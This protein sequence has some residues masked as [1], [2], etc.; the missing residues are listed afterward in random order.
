MAVT[1]T[2]LLVPLTANYA[3][4]RL[5]LE[6]PHV[7]V[8]IDRYSGGIRSIRD[9]E[10]SITYQ[11]PGIGF[12]VTTEVGTVLAEKPLAVNPSG[13]ELVLR[14]AGSG[15]G[16]S[17]HYH[18]GPD[19]R[20][21]EKWLVIKSDD[22][23]PF[24][25]KEVVL[26]DVT[27][28]T[29]VSKIH[30]HDDQT[31]WHCPINI[32]LRSEKGGC[33]AGLE[34]PWWEW[35]PRGKN[36][37]RIGYKPNYQVKAGEVNTSE[38]YFLGVYRKEGIARYS[39][40][41]YPGRHS[42]SLVRFEENTGLFQHFKNKKIPPEAVPQEVLDWGEVW[43]MQD[44]MRQVLP[45][46]PLPEDG[47]WIWQNG[48]WAGLFDPK[49]E[50]L[51]RLKA[52]GVHDIMTAHTWYGR[53]NH[54]M[55]ESY[56]SQ[57]RIEPLGFPVDKGNAGLPSDAG[58]AGGL[59]SLHGGEHSPF[60]LDQFT[61]DFRA[62]PIM[63][64]FIDY[65]R[66]IGV[67]VSSFSLPGIWFNQKPEW[68]S[69]DEAGKPSEY[70]FGRKVSCSASDEYMKHLMAVHEAVFTKYQPRWWGWDG[71]W[72]SYWEVPAYRPGP[73]GLGPDPCYAKNHG[74]LPG[75]NF[76]K[77][78]KNIQNFLMEIR[79]HHPRMCLE[80]YLG[81]K[82]GGPWALRYLN[83]DDNYFETNGADMNRLQTWHNQND[84]FRP[85]YKN[86]AAIF[87]EGSKD[88]QFNVIST[89]STT[90]Y[91]QI[92]PGFKALSLKENQEFLKKWR[93]WASAN[94]AYL[95]VKRDLFECPGYSPVD[96]SSHILGDRGFL[97]L[98]PGGFDTRTKHSKTLRASIPISRWLGFSEKPD[99]VYQITEVYP[100]ERA[101]WGRYRYGEEF[102][103]DMPK[104]SAVILSLQ[105]TRVGEKA[106][107]A[108][109]SAPA[110]NVVVVKAFSDAVPD[111]SEPVASVP[112][113]RATLSSD[114]NQ[115]ITGWGCFPGW[116]DSGDKIGTD[117]D[118]QKAIYR[119]LGM[120]VGRVKIMPNYGNWDGSLN[121]LAIDSHL[122]R[123]IETMRDYGI[124]TWIATTWSPPGFMKTFDSE[125]GK[126]DGQPNRLRPEFE[127]AFAKYYAQVL[128]YLRDVKKLGTPV[129][130]TIQNEPDFAANWDG[131]PYEPD[132]WRRVTKKLRK[133]LDNENLTTVKIHGP[134]HNHC[135]LGKF[136]GDEL[137]AV[138]S[139]PEL[140]KA[141][142]G[143]AFHSYSEGKESGGPAAVEARNLILKFKRELKKGDAIWQTENCSVK[144]EDLTVSAI[145]H[146]RS[147]M[148]DMGYLEVNCY[149]YWL[150]ASDRKQFS[151]EELIFQGTKTK[152]YYVFQKLWNSVI[153]GSFV[154]KT[155]S[156][157]DDPD[158]SNFGPDPMDMLAFISDK[159]SVVLLTNAT[160]VA[161]YLDIRGLAGTQMSLFRTSNTEDMAAVGSQPI[162]H[163]AST[164]FLPG[165][166]ILILE[167]DGGM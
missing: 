106:E 153:P 155:F 41:P 17:L 158:M 10:Q 132:Q 119:D 11:V 129:Y 51:D 42:T 98:F 147:M 15:L 57:T 124:T 72:M 24:F 154:V 56:L 164:V 81:L 148:R 150:G 166:S 96:G 151:G 93:S 71:R 87:G 128:V 102:L 44:F 23:T 149:I 60:E 21:I 4:E 48:W 121:T 141:L 31:I 90:S 43:A 103:Y 20:F 100:R 94:H 125:K 29:P 39:H 16:V 127:D 159:K 107:H 161:R 58:P 89:L 68:G 50:I 142:D 138:K 13:G 47:Y 34:Y 97:F 22:G 25:L 105:P 3:A 18:L 33:F 66:R 74:H 77:E 165:H 113:Y 85:V 163:G 12:M 92:G 131:C 30:F 133:T 46:L 76:Y 135:T 122:A 53:G 91:C 7:A 114:V 9:K 84:R 143:I 79:R 139:D 108:A 54:P 36:G 80:Q 101:D 83:A 136:F 120:T 110:E 64:Q 26:E 32:F 65:G 37:F 86:Y 14:F 152:L 123:Q 140:L 75:D 95:K 134:D 145:R 130:V 137:S 111:R 156:L 63:E 117:K 78:W 82:R 49:T 73:K 116:V 112:T 99:T 52:S 118:L 19:D 5:C 28:A 88:F 70:L 162:V 2:L 6:N 38:K 160:T 115:P 1:A 27:A 157:N 69:L 59:H 104:D 144:R 146:V 55:P 109:L 35:K 62:P 126:V 67:H 45:D 167:T 8:E 61:P 40:G